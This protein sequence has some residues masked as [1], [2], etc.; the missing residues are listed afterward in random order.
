MMTSD[1]QRATIEAAVTV[2]GVE[3][4]TDL[5]CEEAGELLAALGHYSRGRC[6]IE[7]V[8]EESADVAIMLAQLASIFGREDCTT[9]REAMPLPCGNVDDAARAALGLLVARLMQYKATNCE[10]WNVVLAVGRA[11]SAVGLLVAHHGMGEEFEAA[12]GRKLDRLRQ[13]IAERLESGQELC[14]GRFGWSGDTE[15]CGV[16]GG[17]GVRG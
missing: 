15:A 11:L 12:R 7:A 3:A 4:Q 1:T 13:R 17:G 10:R 5:A 6:G 8:A 2:Y 14:C 9:A 16:R